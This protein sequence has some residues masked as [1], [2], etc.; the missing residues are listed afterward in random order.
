MEKAFRW[1]ALKSERL[2][3]TRGASFEEIIGS[4]FLGA[5][6]HPKREGQLLLFFDFKGYVWVVPCVESDDCIFLKTAYPS[7]KYRKS[8]GKGG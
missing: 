3:K 1:N 7:R 5:K 4:E 6:E 8:F 2:K